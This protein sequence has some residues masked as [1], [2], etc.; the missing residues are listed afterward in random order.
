MMRTKKTIE[1]QIK[2]YERNIEAWG[3]C[4][5]ESKNYTIRELYRAWITRE[6]CKI[7]ILKWV[8]KQ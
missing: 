3:S 7:E 1:N 6:E 5:A 2:Q 8:L 4:M